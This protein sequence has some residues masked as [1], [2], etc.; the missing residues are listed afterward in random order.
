MEG[1]NDGVKDW[2]NEVMSF[3]EQGCRLSTAKQVQIYKRMLS[4]FH[5]QHSIIPSLHFFLFSCPIF[6]SS[7]IP[8]F[9]VVEKQ[10]THLN[11]L[12]NQ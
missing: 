12:K 3:V 5:A 6:H 10:N 1:W 8:S 11:P 2:K 7:N 9:Q 4:D